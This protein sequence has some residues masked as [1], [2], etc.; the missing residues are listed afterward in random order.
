MCVPLDFAFACE[1]LRNDTRYGTL[2]TTGVR[3]SPSPDQEGNKLGG[4][5]GTRANSTTWRREL[6]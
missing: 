1:T 5:S 3:I 4:T 6:S 2:A